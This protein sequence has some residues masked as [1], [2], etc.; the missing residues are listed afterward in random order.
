MDA[1]A[2]EAALEERARAHDLRLVIEII[3]HGMWRA[4]LK[5]T[6]DGSIR[7]SAACR[8]RHQAMQDLYDMG[9]PR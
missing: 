6:P 4:G 5:T 3:G 9:D 8:D 7:L 2:L 1:D